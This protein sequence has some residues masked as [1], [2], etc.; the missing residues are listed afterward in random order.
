MIIS[1]VKYFSHIIVFFFGLIGYVILVFDSFSDS[2]FLF[3]EYINVVIA[4]NIFLLLSIL[5]YTIYNGRKFKQQYFI[6]FPIDKNNYILF[7]FKN[8]L[9]SFRLLFL[10]AYLVSSFFIE[11]ISLPTRI[12]TIFLVVIQYILVILI[13]VL[14]K[15]IFYYKKKF[16]ELLSAYGILS[17]IVFANHNYKAI[18]L[19]YDNSP[20]HFGLYHFNSNSIYAAIL[21]LIITIVLYYFAKEWK[22][23]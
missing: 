13:Y 7:E 21:M 5:F 20:F 15:N 4:G 14:I 8:L 10:L 12:T 16:P 3:T 9:F 11:E 23:K 18:K 22:L 6:V 17:T 19:I 2:K 1:K